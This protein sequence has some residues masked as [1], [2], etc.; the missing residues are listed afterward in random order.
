MVADTKTVGESI[1]QKVGK[2]I[3]KETDNVEYFLRSISNDM[4][5]IG[6]RPEYNPLEYADASKCNFK[7]V[8]LKKITEYD[9]C[10]EIKKRMVEKKIF[11]DGKTAQYGDIVLININGKEEDYEIGSG[12]LPDAVED[13]LKGSKPGDEINVESYSIKI[14][15]VKRLEITD[16]VAVQLSGGTSDNA[17][18]YINYVKTELE[19]KE[20]KIAVDKV[21]NKLCRQCKVKDI[22]EDVMIY[23]V[24]FAVAET[25]KKAGVNETDENEVKKYVNE[26]GFESVDDF[27]IKVNKDVRKNLEKEMK[28][29]AIAEKF[30]VLKDKTGSVSEM[31]EQALEEIERMVLNG[32]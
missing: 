8:K 22:P 15:Q 26:L 3:S 24:S 6:V 18:S 21:I 2:S 10:E 5:D 31:Y 11:T 27:I 14:K 28:V 4:P 12:G 30:G 23:D 32:K 13:K 29:I 25:Y 16:W 20:N 9:I 1:A 19:K 17:D 7:K